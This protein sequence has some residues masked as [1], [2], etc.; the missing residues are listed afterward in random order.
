MCKQSRY[1]HLLFSILIGAVVV[2]CAGF[3]DENTDPIKNNKATYNKDLKE[4][5]EDYP[6]QGSGVHY[7]QWIG[8]M[9]L[10]GWK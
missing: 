10:K 4:C 9:K 5:Q 6:E 8:C 2:A 7:R 1:K 3:P